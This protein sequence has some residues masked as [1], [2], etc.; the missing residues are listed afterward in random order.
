[1]TKITP[2]KA[3]TLI[4]VTSVLG[5]CVSVL[6]EPEPAPTVYR[7]AI[8]VHPSVDKSESPI[9]INVERPDAPAML[10]GHDIVVSPDGRRLS[11]AAGAI[12][13]API[14]Q[15]LR[16]AV[17]DTL[18]DNSRLVG[19]IPKGS[20]RVPYRLNMDIR[21]FEAVFDHGEQAA[22]NC[23]VHLNVSLTE[24][25]GRKIVGAHTI[26]VERRAAGRNISSIVAAQDLATKAA[27]DDLETW[28]NE[29]V[30]RA[31]A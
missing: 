19:V 30:S 27:M 31:G 24:T 28:L 17:V 11:T 29:K 14:P 13:E 12:W 18:A 20:T 23:I 16:S 3:L 15:L 1:M 9:T 5:A 7:L 10:S 4:L 8:P 21:R 6:P 26:Y 2:V 22:P 25:K